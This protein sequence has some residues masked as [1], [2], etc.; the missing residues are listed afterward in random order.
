MQFGYF[1]DLFFFLF[2][3]SNE[4]F[5]VQAR[6]L[7]NNRAHLE[8]TRL[9]GKLEIKKDQARNLVDTRH[10]CEVKIKK[11]EGVYVGVGGNQETD[12]EGDPLEDVWTE[13]SMALE[14]S[15]VFSCIHYR[16]S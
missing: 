6:D 7:L 4:W 11:D 9:F 14:A 1:F 3:P 5:F 16:N 2:L 13:M 8:D 12:N 15:K 10:S